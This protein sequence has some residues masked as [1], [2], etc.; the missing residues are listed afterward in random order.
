[1][2]RK[3]YKKSKKA[4]R[5]VKKR[6]ARRMTRNA[7]LLHGNQVN[8]WFDFE[9]GVPASQT[10]DHDEVYFDL[11]KECSVATLKN[12]KQMK[13]NGTPYI[14]TVDAEIHPKTSAGLTV[15]QNVEGAHPFRFYAAPCTWWLKAACRY[16]AR[17]RLDMLKQVPGYQKMMHRY[18]RSLRIYWSDGMRDATFMT[19]STSGSGIDPKS[20]AKQ[21][22]ITYGE[23]DYT[24]YT[25]PDGTDTSDEFTLHLWGDHEGTTNNVTGVG[26]LKSYFEGKQHPRSWADQT[27]GSESSQPFSSDDPLLNLLDTGTHI[28]ELA[29]DLYDKNDLPP[30]Q[31][32]EAGLA[33]VWDKP[34][35]VGVGTTGTAAEGVTVIRNMK[36]PLGLLNMHLY[37]GGNFEMILTVKKI[38]AMGKC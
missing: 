19:D 5:R 3:R 24:P 13:A 28:D 16:G 20:M 14:Y 25:S 12:L 22:G 15:P 34:R 8:L 32:T 2:A 38:Q 36:V 23:W 1:M 29:A 18:N 33:N 26:L 17:R 11:A 37:D 21:Y 27:I 7:D 10:P 30:W 6:Y 9:Y 31:T 4:R 35:V